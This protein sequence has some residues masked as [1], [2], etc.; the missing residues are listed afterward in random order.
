MGLK[1]RLLAE[2]SQ[3]ESAEQVLLLLGKASKDSANNYY[4]LQY[5]LSDAW[6]VRIYCFN[7]T[8]IELDGQILKQ[9][10]K[11]Q[12]KV[13]ELLLTIIA[14]GG[15]DVY[16]EQVYEVLWPDSDGDLAHQALETVISR[17]RKLIGKSAILV[18]DGRISLNY[19]YCWVDVL[20]FESTLKELDAELQN[21]ANEAALFKLSKRLFQLYQPS[22]MSELDSSIVMSKLKQLQNSFIILIKRLISY[23]EK[24]QNHRHL[25]KLLEQSLERIQQFESDHKELIVYYFNQSSG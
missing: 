8:L 10:G 19:N 13:I 22:R 2:T 6:L 12:K 25:C 1:A 23:H 7:H 20:V 17:L 16:H 9:D 11:S 18:K 21:E 3:W 15:Q 14:L 4:R 5:H 24:Q